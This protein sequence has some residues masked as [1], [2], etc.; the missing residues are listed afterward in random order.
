MPDVKVFDR[1]TLSSQQ[2][3]QMMETKLDQINPIESRPKLY[4]S[5]PNDNLGLYTVSDIP[6]DKVVQD[7]P[8]NKNEI[9]PTVLNQIQRQKIEKYFD[10]QQYRVPKV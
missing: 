1:L 10:F 4:S 6:P 5:F 9:E 2:P 3:R 7:I 8:L